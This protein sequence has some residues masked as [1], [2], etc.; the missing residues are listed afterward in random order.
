MAAASVVFAPAIAWTQADKGAEM[1]V[2]VLRET[3]GGNKQDEILTPLGPLRFTDSEGKENSVELAAFNYIGDMHVRF[4]FDAPT[5]M[6]NATPE[7]FVRLN[8]NAQ[9]ALSLAIGNLKRL[10]GEPTTST[11]MGRLMQVTGK[12]DNFNSSYFLDRDLWRGLTR[13]NH[14]GVVVGVPKRGVLLY[15]AAADTE[16]VNALR[17]SIAGLHESS[18]QLRVSSGLYLFKDDRWSVFQAP[19]GGGR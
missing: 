17:A 6:Q 15:A 11:L 10:Y 1:L 16:S 9:S 7:D 8:L 4:V 18:G 13:R 12:E 5:T 19:I 3:V 14:E 2:P